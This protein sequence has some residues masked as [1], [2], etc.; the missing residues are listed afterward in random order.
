MTESGLIGS[1]QRNTEVGTAPATASSPSGSEPSLAL[2]GDLGASDGDTVSSPSPCTTACATVATSG[3]G[4]FTKPQRSPCFGGLLVGTMLV[5]TAGAASGVAR[6]VE[7]LVTPA[8]CDGSQLAP[9]LSPDR[10]CA[11]PRSSA[12]VPW[13]EL[14]SIATTVRDDITQGRRADGSRFFCL[15]SLRSSTCHERVVSRHSA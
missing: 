15:S 11:A 5:T 14:P 12:A 1:S 13:R 2:V 10:L 4:A 9:R 7:P 6:T 8:G 3:V